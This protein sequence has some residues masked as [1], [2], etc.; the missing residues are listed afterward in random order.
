MTYP[1]AYATAA[2]VMAALDAVWLT[3]MGPRLYRPALAPLLTEGFRPAP[4]VAFYVIFVAG[5]VLFG[6]S[7]ALASGRWVTAAVRGALF[8]FF[9]Y[10]T[11]DLTNQA[12]LKV[13]PL[14]LTLVDI[15]WGTVLAGVTATAAFLAARRFG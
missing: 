1:I 14:K 8:G 2:L 3:L 11:Y 13:W 9:C 5:V 10:A 7:P 4:A 6:V 12:T 15:T